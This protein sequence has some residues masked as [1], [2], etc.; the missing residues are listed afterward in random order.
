[1]LASSH[2]TAEDTAKDMQAIPNTHI[3]PTPAEVLP[4]TRV[5]LGT[6]KGA[7]IKAQS[8]AQQAA[9][10]LDSRFA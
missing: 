10:L 4:K 7:T 9:L 8:A 5:P 3:S 6:L 1:M 2:G